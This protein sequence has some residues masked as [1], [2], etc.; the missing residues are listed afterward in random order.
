MSM[1]RAAMVLLHRQAAAEEFNARK[2][3]GQAK[4]HCHDL[5]KCV[6]VETVFFKDLWDI[7]DKWEHQMHIGLRS[8]SPI[9]TAPVAVVIGF[10]RALQ[11]HMPILAK[12]AFRPWTESLTVVLDTLFSPITWGLLLDMI[13]QVISSA[14][15]QLRADEVRL[16]SSENRFAVSQQC[17]NVAHQW[18]R[19]LVL[20]SKHL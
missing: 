14:G 20:L 9:E 11:Q 10:I 19:S 17:Y 18:S 6:A 4:R 3:R 5:R 13:G 15:K 7:K 16:Q 12:C 1:A 2:A 8:I